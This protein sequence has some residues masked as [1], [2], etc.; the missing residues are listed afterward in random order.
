LM[1]GSLATKLRVMRAERGLTLRQAA[2]RLGVR[3]GTLS[4]LE[5]GARHPHDLTLAKIAK[6]YGVPVEELLEEASPLAPAPSASP[7]PDAGAAGAGPL[8][9]MALA[10]ARRDEEKLWQAV[11]RAGASEG[12]SAVTEYEED[13]FRAQVRALGFPDEYFEGFIWPLVQEAVR[14]SHLEQENA[15]L[16]EELTRVHADASELP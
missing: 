1:Q 3:P 2:P 9:D 6:G 10:A 13:K 15:R 12:M 4:E 14:A 8:L 7:L 11:A 5:R 16:K